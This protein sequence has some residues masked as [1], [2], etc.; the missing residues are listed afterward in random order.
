VNGGSPLLAE[1][2]M[3]LGHELLGSSGVPAVPSSHGSA[4]ASQSQADGS[5]DASGTAGHEGDSPLE[6]VTGQDRLMDSCRGLL[7]GD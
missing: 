6:L 1:A 2:L 3:E 5:P 4:L 7:D